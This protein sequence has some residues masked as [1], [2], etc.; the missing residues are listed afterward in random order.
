MEP[1]L[2]LLDWLKPFLP[3]LGPEKRRAICPLY[4]AA[5]IDP[6]KTALTAATAGDR[7]DRLH[8]F[9]SSGVWDH[10][11]LC[12][13]L[14]R[15]AD[16]QAGGPDAVLVVDDVHLP[17][18]GRHA[19]GAAPR[20][21]TPTGAPVNCQTLVALTLVRGDRAVPVGLRLMLPEAWLED[22]DRLDKAEV[23]D[24]YRR[25]QS[26]PDIA[27]EEID[28]LIALGAGFGLVLAGSDYGASTAFRQ[29]LR[30]R[31][32]TSIVGVPATLSVW[33]VA[34]DARP[35]D[36]TPMTT[37]AALLRQ[38]RWTSDG[39]GSHA[40]ARVRVGDD[41]GLRP[42]GRDRSGRPAGE[43]IWLIG[44]TAASGECHYHLADAAETSRPEALVATL[45]SRLASERATARMRDDLGLERFEARSWQGLHRHFLMTMMACAYLQHRS[46]APPPH[47][48]PLKAQG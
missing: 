2:A 15:Q 18:T 44:T 16:H 14:A 39:A 1:D 30:A 11:S 17:K 38:A 47:A 48:I 24:V 3:L 19:V 33:P 8:H 40:F 25:P 23:P 29:G 5:L 46:L 35:F 12:D 43:A 26:G 7:Y 42:S 28:R 36:P 41:D 10:R 21:L 20:R 4:V 9:I 13:E 27:L 31:R 37:A 32:L 45:S 22:T 34:D 6:D